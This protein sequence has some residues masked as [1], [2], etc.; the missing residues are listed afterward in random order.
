MEPRC[1]SLRKFPE[2]VTTLELASAAN[3]LVKTSAIEMESRDLFT[4]TTVPAQY[5]NI[6][7][8]SDVYSEAVLALKTVSTKPTSLARHG[9]DTSPSVMVSS[10]Q[11]A[12]GSSLPSRIALHA[13]FERKKLSMTMKKDELLGNLRPRT[14]NKSR[15][16]GKEIKYQRS[17]VEISSR[18][19]ILFFGAIPACSKVNNPPLFC[20]R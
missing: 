11:T 20:C 4:F 18:R 5:S 6:Y 10:I 1:Q 16:R 3:T 15:P 7:R 17:Q 2:A 13:R 19:N 14:P 12:S 9:I 8:L